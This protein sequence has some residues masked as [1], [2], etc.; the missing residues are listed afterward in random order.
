VAI[1]SDDPEVSG[2][3][4]GLGQMSL[5]EHLRELRHRLIVSAIAVAI[6]ATIAFIFYNRILSFLV[7][8][9]CE[10]IRK[11]PHFAGSNGCK[12][13]I[14]DPLE[15]F[16]T[17]LKVSGYSGLLLAA[18]VVLWQ[19]ARF[20]SPGLHKR[21]KRY[22]IPFVVASLLLFALGA[23]VAL[24]TF[25]QALNF[26]I[27]VGGSNISTFFSPAKY[28]GLITLIILAFGAAFE[29]PIILVFLELIGVVPSKK[30]RSWRRPAVVVIFV[31]AAV[32][33]PSQD[34]YSLFAMAIPMYIFYET[35]IIIGRILKK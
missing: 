12:L 11:H 30:L 29:F 18:P 8:P 4:P 6:G 2:E 9:Y 17:R 31:V 24:L 10:V 27:G 32:I 34:P 25:P 23:A 14:T 1:I 20:V 5:M 15:G 28:L 22:I 13:I 26:L 7:H 35:S 19:F 21:E 33:T 3:D 16:T